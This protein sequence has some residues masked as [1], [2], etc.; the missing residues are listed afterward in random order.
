MT[1]PVCMTEEHAKTKWCPFTGPSDGAGRCLASGCMAWRF[2][3]THIPNEDNVLVASGDTHG[4]CG[5]AGQPSS[6]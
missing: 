6:K 4:Y 1:T 3:E 5:A 2:M